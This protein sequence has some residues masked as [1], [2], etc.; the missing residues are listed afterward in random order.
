M[1]INLIICIL[2]MLNFIEAA[3]YC[4]D[5]TWGQIWVTVSL[6]CELIFYRWKLTWTDGNWSP[7]PSIAK[8]TGG[9]VAGSGCSSGGRLRLNAGRVRRYYFICPF[10]FQRE[11]HL[12]CAS[13]IASCNFP[14]TLHR[15]NHGIIYVSGT[16][17]CHCIHDYTEGKDLSW[18]DFET[19]ATY[20]AAI[21]IPALKMKVSGI[22]NL[23]VNKT[24]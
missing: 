12:L 15:D 10:E 8:G 9:T 14:L 16:L 1:I 6:D 11:L 20:S 13:G 2:L 24:N 19:N 22:A 23:I 3:Q 4:L 21:T 18:K 5:D 7:L 17:N